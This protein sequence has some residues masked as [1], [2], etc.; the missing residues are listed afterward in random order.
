MCQI[1]YHP[2]TSSTS[3]EIVSIFSGLG[4]LGIIDPSRHTLHGGGGSEVVVV[5]G[6]SDFELVVA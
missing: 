6:G 5:V 2:G 1:H 4:F 3:R